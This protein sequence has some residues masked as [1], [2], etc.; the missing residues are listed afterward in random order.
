MSY[1]FDLN[2]SERPLVI[3]Q[4]RLSAL[5]WSCPDKGDARG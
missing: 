2:A 1:R 3:F 4:S 5:H